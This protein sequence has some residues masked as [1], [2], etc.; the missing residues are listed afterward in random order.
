MQWH[1]TKYEIIPSGGGHY[2]KIRSELYVPQIKIVCAKVLILDLAAN[3]I[4]EAGCSKLNRFSCRRVLNKVDDHQIRFNWSQT[5]W[6]GKQDNS[7]PEIPT[8]CLT[9]TGR[10]HNHWT[11]AVLGMLDFH[12][13]Y[14]NRF[15]W[16]GHVHSSFCK[17]WPYI[18]VPLLGLLYGYPRA[19]ENIEAE[20]KEALLRESFVFT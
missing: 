15:A 3:I 12:F 9:G 18:M 5:N 11:C 2:H 19:Q 17:S 14:P 16:L 13:I 6:H 20:V 10:I 4:V 7:V 1:N 8:Q